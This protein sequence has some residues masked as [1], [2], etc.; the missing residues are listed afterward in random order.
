MANNPTQFTLLSRILHW[1]MA[2]MLLA[3]LFIG[4][5]MVASLGN[6]HRLVA[7][8]R[9]LGIMILILAAIRLVNRMVTTLPPFP[10]TMSRRERFLA[11]ASERLLYT[12]MFALP[13]VGWGMLSAGH[14]PI[15]MF[16]PVHLPAI[17][18][19]SST[20]YA[21]L[22]KAHTILAYLLFLTFLAHLSAVLFH[23]MIVRDRLLDRMALWPIRTHNSI[24]KN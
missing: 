14:Y 8:H 15:V 19:Q 9:P 11:S 23:T 21:V 16:G 7:I 18:P 6:Y 5:S 3:V 2:A 4:V 12:L 10:P 20:L 1:L 22:R 17:L 13:L 24:N